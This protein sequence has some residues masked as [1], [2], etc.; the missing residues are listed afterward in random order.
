MVAERVAE[1]LN[2][3]LHGLF[4]ES[5]TPYLLGEDVLDP[6]GGA[7]KVTRGLATS[8]PDRVLTTPLSENGMVGVANGLALCGNRVVVEFMFGDFLLLAMDQIVN[9]AAKSVSMY[10]R[11]VPLPLLVRCPVGGNRGYGAT[12][13]QS[14]QKFLVGVPGL[15]LWEMSPFTDAAR[16]FQRVFGT[17]QPAVLF[18]DKVLYTRRMFEA[19]R[20]DGEWTYADAGG[21]AEWTVVQHRS[22]RPPDVVIITAGGTAHRCLT[23]ASTLLNDCGITVAV[24]VPARLHPCDPE[25][26]LPLISAASRVVTVEEGTPDGSWSGVLAQR[27]HDQLWSS[28]LAPVHI[29]TSQAS[30][31]PAASHLEREVLVGAEDVVAAV[32]ELYGRTAHAQAHGV[33][34]APGPGQAAIGH[35]GRG[36]AGHDGNGRSAGGTPEADTSSAGIAVTLPQLNANDEAA[37]LVEWLV[38]EGDQVT[39]GQPVAVVETSKTTMEVE[40]PADG[41]I[42]LLAATGADHPFGTRLALIAGAGA[43]AAEPGVPA[44]EPG[45]PTE[46]AASIQGAYASTPSQHQR[47]VVASPPARRRQRTIQAGVAATV[48]ASHRAIPPAFAARIV[49]AGPA[50]AFLDERG[51]Q[52]GAPID[53]GAFLIGALAR[54]HG[55]HRALFA[56]V[57]ADG[58]AASQSTPDVA[59]T[60]D[61]GQGLFMP[62]IRDPATMPLD[63]LADR[64][65]EL[66]MAALGGGL[67]EDDL[68]TSGVGLAVSLNLSGGADLVQPIVMPRMSCIVSVGAVRPSVT[69]GPDNTAR[70]GQ[71]VTL[72]ITHDH[73]VINGRPAAQLL[74]DLAGCFADPAAAFPS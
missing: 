18:E 69:L 35:N 4:A 45:V 50:L 23:A 63:V 13:S 53:L 6:Y 2:R 64:L 16:I 7:F 10:G 52:T 24:L 72:G 58:V 20:V 47:P 55:R 61:A 33:P 30:I 17:S 71:Q 15:E 74:A 49:D 44:T 5:A 62:V 70:P 19:G 42:R 56:P 66:Q 65:I 25:P 46:A 39:C 26:V 9:F 57:S 48:S 38:A 31:I 41:R 32:T 21:D 8:F 3:A 34:A 37:L 29:L 67:A 22:P 54:L 27:L 12:H 1:N 11:P 36:T 40:A 68:D 60:I 59:V 51:E 73:R 43:P 14:V 28:L